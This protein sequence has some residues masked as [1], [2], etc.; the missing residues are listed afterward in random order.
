MLEAMLP[1]SVKSLQLLYKVHLN[2]RKSVLSKID[3]PAFSSR[4]SLLPPYSCLDPIGESTTTTTHPQKVDKE[5]KI[6]VYPRKLKSSSTIKITKVLTLLE[7]ILMFYC[8]FPLLHPK[9]LLMQ[10]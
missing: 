10:I 4:Y 6:Q 7:V 3:I 5:Q 2:P 1:S 9:K 8:N